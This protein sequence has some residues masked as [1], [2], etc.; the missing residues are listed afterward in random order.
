MEYVTFI[1]ALTKGA[2]APASLWDKMYNDELGVER[3]GPDREFAGHNG[4]KESHSFSAWIWIPT[5]PRKKGI[6][7]VFEANS[8]IVGDPNFVAYEILACALGRG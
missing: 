4:S 7:A 6:I 1:D 3:F 5:S 8:F 2:I